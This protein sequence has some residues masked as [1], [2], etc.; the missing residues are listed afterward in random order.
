MI[1][2]VVTLTA[3]G[4]IELVGSETEYNW[5]L[6]NDYITCALAGGTVSTGD[7]PDCLGMWEVDPLD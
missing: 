4:S 5:Q 3:L 7:G 6:T 1:L 2:S